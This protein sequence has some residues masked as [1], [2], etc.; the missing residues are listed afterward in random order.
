VPK[1]AELDDLNEYTWW[2]FVAAVN[3]ELR[4]HTFMTAAVVFVIAF[5]LTILGSVYAAWTIKGT[6]G[7]LLVSDT[8]AL[9]G[10]GAVLVVLVVASAITYHRHTQELHQGLA[11][12]ANQWSEV[13]MREGF[14]VEFM[15]VRKSF[16]LV[17]SWE[18][19]RLVFR[20]YLPREAEETLE[21]LVEVVVPPKPTKTK[22]SILPPLKLPK[23]GRK[24][25][26]SHPT[27]P[28]SALDFPHAAAE[29][30]LPASSKAGIEPAS[31]SARA[32]RASKHSKKR[33]L[34]V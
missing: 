10:A 21:T 27:S 14:D 7:G 20:R 18:E 23:L 25:A 1:P 24:G 12:I 8:A 5:Y 33:F 16:L 17:F 29:E 9:A 11:R 13:F 4:N 6:A 22:A 26:T 15:R 2:S 19:S 34:V 32:K 3:E 28:Q 30:L 31:P